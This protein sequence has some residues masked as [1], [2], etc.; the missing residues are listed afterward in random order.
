MYIACALG[1]LKILTLCRVFNR[2]PVLLA[3]TPPFR[4]K[5]ERACP[6]RAQRA[7]G[8]GY[9]HL[10]LSGI[11]AW[12]TRPLVFAA[13]FAPAGFFAPTT[14]VIQLPDPAAPQ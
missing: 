6:Q 11:K 7:D 5:G 3:L 10:F 12:A 14:V 8:M 4:T 2:L 13:S 9:P 1:P